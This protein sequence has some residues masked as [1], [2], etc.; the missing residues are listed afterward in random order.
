MTYTEFRFLLYT[1]SYERSVHFYSRLLRM[2]ILEQWDG[3]EGR[4]TILDAGSGGCAFIEIFDGAQARIIS[5]SLGI[6]LRI[7]SRQAVD[8]FYRDLGEAQAQGE[9]W[10]FHLVDM[11]EVKS[12]GHYSFELSDPDGIHV[13]LYSIEERG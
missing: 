13:T 10:G 1:R 11:P 9:D 3:P 5:G 8:A 4:G 6:A 7:E 2:P 12:W